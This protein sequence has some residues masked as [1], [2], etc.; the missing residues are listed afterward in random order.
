MSST[1]LTYPL[2]AAWR[3]SRILRGI[4]GIFGICA[5][6]VSTIVLLGLASWDLFSF[7]LGCA[8]FFTALCLAR[9][10]SKR[11]IAGEREAFLW[12]AL[13]LWVFLMVS[14]AIFTHVQSTASAAKGHVDPGAIYQA[15]SWILSAAVLVFITCFRPA[16]LRRLF[17]GPLKWASIFAIVVV[18][19]CPLSPKPSYSLALAFKLCLIVLTLHAIGE[20][21]DDETAIFRLFAGTF[22]GTLIIVSKAFIAQLLEPDPFRS[23]RLPNVGLSGTCGVL[24]LLCLLCFFLKKNLFFLMVG[25]YS[26]FV[27]ILCGTKGGMVASFVSLMMFFVLLKRPAQAIAA[28]FVFGLVLI[29][30]VLFTPLGKSLERYSEGGSAT[31]L[32][33]RTNLWANAWPNI[34]SHPIFGNGYRASRFLSEEVPGAFKDAGNMHNSF[35]EVLYNNGLAGLI[36]ILVINVLIVVNLKAVILRPPTLELRYY[37]VAAL[38]LETHF[39]VWGLVAVTFGGQPD[40]RFMTFFAILVISMFLRAQCDKKYWKTVYGRRRS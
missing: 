11:A 36:P 37:A 2:R 40:D 13:V 29:L 28:S 5:I 32:T 27:M 30:C 8:I 16:Y 10:L 20:A 3:Q 38:A 12:S 34:S 9:P 39:F 24:L 21:I 31:T 6:A 22:L 25:M 1:S 19:S 17:V 18:I 33:G 15:L 14:E 26:V 35:L 23:G 7:L 4:V